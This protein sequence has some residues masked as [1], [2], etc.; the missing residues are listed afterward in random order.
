MKGSPNQ[1]I[2]FC[3]LRRWNK[4]SVSLV[5][6]GPL[7]LWDPYKYLHDFNILIHELCTLFFLCMILYLSIYLIGCNNYFNDIFMNLAI[8]IANYKIMINF[9][10][11]MEKSIIMRD[12]RHLNITSC[13]FESPRY[14][15]KLDVQH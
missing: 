12:L 8:Q 6:F 11:N 7:K 13:M 3:A 14:R 2:M 4:I 5:W 10:M 1:S 9:T 15:G